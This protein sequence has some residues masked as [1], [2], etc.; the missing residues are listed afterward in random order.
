MEFFRPD[1]ASRI[2]RD[3]FAALRQTGDLVTYINELMDIKLAIT[4]MTDEEACDKFIRGLSLKSMRAHIRQY[5]ATTLKEAIHAALSYDSAQKEEDFYSR[6]NT[7]TT[8]RRVVDDPMEL[9]AIDQH[10]NNNNNRQ[11]NNQ[12]RSN[13]NNS[14]R[15]NGNNYYKGNNNGSSYNCGN[16]S[17]HSLV[18]TVT[19]KVI[20]SEIVV[21]VLQ[22]SGD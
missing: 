2:A 3:K 7:T 19:N 20:L 15:S 16:N 5:E 1:N 14:S 6:P 18:T 11:Y 21:L 10:N 4:T 13:N 12:S 17:G 22:I 8:T 9:D